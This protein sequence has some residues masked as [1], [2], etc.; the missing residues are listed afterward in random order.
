MT[1]FRRVVPTLLLAMSL[2]GP[3]LAQQLP[4]LPESIRS[5]G[6]LR[7]GVRCDQPPY[8]F[9]GPDGGFAGVEVDMA[10]Q[11]AAWAFGS[12][13]K[14]ELACVT[15]EN[16]IPQLQARRVDLL[17]ATL[18]VTPDRARVIDFSDAYRWG[19][20]DMLVKRDSP[21]QKLDDVRD[22]TVIMLRGTTQASWFDENMPGLNA[23][24]LNTASDAL[25]ALIQGRGEAYAHDAAT[26]VVI[27]T[28]DPSLRLVG[29][30]F[31]VSDAAVGVRKGEPEWL[32]WINAA[33][34][35]MKAENL[36]M[37]WV[38]RWVPNETRPFYTSAFNDPRPKAR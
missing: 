38:E 12:T 29:E 25:Q 26:L 30:P 32:A 23:L 22:R 34:A 16:R 13:D 5:Q 27:A 3:A 2:A 28:R 1:L 19:G 21:I 18:G 31:A 36:Y 9:R 37:L 17:I 7:A 15:A 33:L 10:R 24:R 8:G 4:P 6:V 11:M 20:S 35:R 14:A